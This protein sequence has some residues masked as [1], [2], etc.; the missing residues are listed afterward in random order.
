MILLLINWQFS[1]AQNSRANALITLL[2][3]IPSDTNRVN[4]LIAISDALVYDNPDKSLKYAI[5]SF[6]LA[7]ELEFRKGVA[8]ATN[9]IG[10]AYWSKGDMAKAFEELKRSMILADGLEDFSLDARN[11]GSVGVVFAAIDDNILAIKYYTDALNIYEFLGDRRGFIAMTNNIGKS[12]IDIAKFDSAEHYL[13]TAMS[14]ITKEYDF[15]KPI[16][17]FNIGDSKTK[18]DEFELALPLLEQALRLAEDFDDQRAMVRSFET[19]AKINLKD[20]MIEKALENTQNAVDLS[21]GMNVKELLQITYKTHSTALA[22]AGRFDE[23][24]LFR[25]LSSIYQDSLSSA[26][27]RNQLAIFNYQQEQSELALLRKQSEVNQAESEFQRLTI[28]ALSTI[29]ILAALAA[30]A[31]YLSRRMKSKAN[32]SLEQKNEEINLQKVELDDLNRVKDKILAI[33]SHD[34]RTPLV[35]LHSIISM[36]EQKMITQKEF[37]EVLPAVSKEMMG[38]QNL[39]D[40]LLNWAKSHM[41]GDFVKPEE[42]KLKNIVDEQIESLC[43]S[44]E[45]KN[46]K[47]ENAL[48]EKDLAYAD[49]NLISLVVRNIL[50]NSVKFSYED[51]SIKI[52][53]TSI[54]NQIGLEI[55]DDGIGMDQEVSA[56]LFKEARP[57]NRGTIGEKG[58]GIGLMLCNDFIELNKGQISVESEVGKGSVFTI[59][60]PKA[61]KHVEEREEPKAHE[62]ASA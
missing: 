25:D 6:N 49:Q 12:Y 39:L 13:N 55:A 21:R 18:Q 22:A 32:K 2:D 42:I 40:N 19:I 3:G 38:A 10:R 8:H 36:I 53:A 26:V 30:Y 56:S 61:T 5:E 29:A 58:S 4:T 59:S 46:L 16:V 62:L 48:S 51:G 1:L 33:I 44:I 31:F 15:M 7:E 14:R 24:Y 60:L 43:K 27:T 35:S 11:L 23:A 41:S 34:F 47:I 28:Y 52:T 57:S 9:R 20:G 17:L 54:G 37:E 50:S 45:S